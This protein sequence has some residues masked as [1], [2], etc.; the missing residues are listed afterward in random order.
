MRNIEDI[1]RERFLT[2]YRHVSNYLREVRNNASIAC[3]LSSSSS[4]GPGRALGS[5]TNDARNKTRDESEDG[6]AKASFERKKYEFDHSEERGRGYNTA[7]I[8]ETR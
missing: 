1:Y 3:C 5:W 4:T 6:R 8:R 7:G 2:H